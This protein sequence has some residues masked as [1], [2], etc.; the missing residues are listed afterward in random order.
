[1]YRAGASNRAGQAGFISNSTGGT[2]YGN[3]DGDGDIPLDT[4]DH[5]L[6]GERA[7]LIKMD[8]EG[9]EL[10][11][12]KGAEGNDTTISVGFLQ[13]VYIIKAGFI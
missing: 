4:I 13:F 11:A 3:E 6:G 1:M 9:S 5:V 12:L 8:I 7:T 10:A 2:F